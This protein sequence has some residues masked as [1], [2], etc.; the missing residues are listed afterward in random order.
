MPTAAHGY[1]QIKVRG[2]MEN[3]MLCCMCDYSIEG[4]LATFGKT[5]MVIGVFITNH[6]AILIWRC[7]CHAGI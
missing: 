4:V 5:G 1:N 2:I 7:V 6:Y 3:F